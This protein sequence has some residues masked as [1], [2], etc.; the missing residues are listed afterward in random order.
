M[1]FLALTAISILPLFGNTMKALP[2]P[3][4][5][6]MLS[7]RSKRCR[8]G[9]GALRASLRPP[10]KPGVRFSRTGLSQGFPN[11]QRQVMVSVR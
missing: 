5:K 4:P 8:V 1:E 7:L 2:L 6:V 10:L 11:G 3:S 9:G